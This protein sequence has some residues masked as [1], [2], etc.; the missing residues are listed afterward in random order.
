M[1]TSRLDDLARHALL[2]RLRTIDSAPGAEVEMDGRRVLL[3]SSNNYLDLAAHPR[4]TE[5]AVKAIGR[6][7][8]G[9]GASRLVSGSLRP[10]RDLSRQR[11][12]SH[13]LRW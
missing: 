11:R 1:F 6:Y 5:A 2:R 4:V 3:F 9:A 7:G 10:H 8:V 13:H 12:P